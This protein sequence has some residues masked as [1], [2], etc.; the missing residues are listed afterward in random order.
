MRTNMSKTCVLHTAELPL[1]SP[2]TNPEDKS[3]TSLYLNFTILLNY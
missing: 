1:S 2:D 3:G